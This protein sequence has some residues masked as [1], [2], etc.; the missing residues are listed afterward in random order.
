MSKWYAS[1]VILRLEKE[2]EPESWK[3]LQVGG[4]DGIS[5]QHLQVMMTNLLQKHWEWKEEKTPMLKHGSVVR[6]TMYLASMDIKTAFDEAR[7]RH[8][9]KNME[10]RSK[11]SALLCEMAGLE[12]G[13]AMFECVDSDFWRIVPFCRSTQLTDLAGL[14]PS[15][16]VSSRSRHTL[17]TGQ[18]QSLQSAGNML[19][20]WF[21]LD[22]LV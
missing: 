3:R 1:C 10:S 14:G 12:E 21:V 18:S 22:S 8:A 15:H 6:P 13:Q 4:D 20:I 7:P 2:K 9:A 5:C 17:G 11:L 16:A 19:L